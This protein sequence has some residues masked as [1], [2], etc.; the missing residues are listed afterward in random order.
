MLVLGRS[1]LGTFLPVRLALASASAIASALALA[2]AFARRFAAFTA[3]ASLRSRAARAWATSSPGERR[4]RA[5]SRDLAMF[6]SVP[7]NSP[8]ARAASRTMRTAR[9]DA[10]PLLV[11]QQIGLRV[12]GGP[13]T[14]KSGC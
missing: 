3:A 10:S 11:D 12:V 14:P 1:A 7:H 13:R 9:G 4:T 5:D 2:S 8:A 6:V